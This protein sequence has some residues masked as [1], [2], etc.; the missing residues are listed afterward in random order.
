MTTSGQRRFPDRCKIS[1]LDYRPAAVRVQGNH[2]QTTHTCVLLSAPRTRQQCIFMHWTWYQIYVCPGVL[3]LSTCICG[4]T[5]RATCR[6]VSFVLVKIV[7]LS[8]PRKSDLWSYI[9]RQRAASNNSIVD[10]L[11]TGPKRPREN[12]VPCRPFVGH[13][14]QD[15]A[16]HGTSLRE[17]STSAAVRHAKLNSD[18]LF[19]SHATD[20]VGCF[21]CQVA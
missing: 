6:A 5:C 13:L 11:A 14:L 2:L 10:T 17:T 19:I 9:R 20:A 21:Y 16:P 7:R 8:V 18:K 1:R 15:G 3:L 12:T 4:T